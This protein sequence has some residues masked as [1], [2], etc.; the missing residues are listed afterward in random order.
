MTEKKHNEQKILPLNQSVE[1]KRMYRMI[2]YWKSTEKKH[3]DNGMIDRQK[4]ER[5]SGG[6]AARE[7]ER[8]R[9]KSENETQSIG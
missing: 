5:S 6:G 4:D 3:P 1:N 9:S 8:N 2:I 7:S